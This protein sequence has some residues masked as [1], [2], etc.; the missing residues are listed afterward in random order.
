MADPMV[1]RIEGTVVGGD[2]EIAETETP[3]VTHNTHHRG[4]EIT[5]LHGKFMSGLECLTSRARLMTGRRAALQA[6][7]VYLRE[8]RVS[9]VCVLRA[10]RPLRAIL[11][12]A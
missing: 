10:L 6:S 7:S 1:T 4:T 8:L 3:E 9:A 5:G 2:S 12:A 11:R